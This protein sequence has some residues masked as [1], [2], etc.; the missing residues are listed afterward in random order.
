MPESLVKLED[1]RLLISDLYIPFANIERAI[2]WPH[3]AGRFEND[4]EHSFS[5]AIASAY[6]A[7]K[8]GLDPNKAAAYATVHDL[9]EVEAGDTSVW[10][11]EGLK[12]KHEREKAGFETM[13][14]KFAMFP[15]MLAM[16]EK[17]EKLEDEEACLVFTLDKSLALIM[18]IEDNGKFWKDNGITYEAHREKANIQV[19]DKLSRYPAILALY[20]ELLDIAEANKER[21]FAPQT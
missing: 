5:L 7:E 16:V 17:Y 10:D 12:T 13:K 4:A 6:A 21:L 8:L 19:R 11:E 20:E 9:L 3:E 2:T 18:I 15:W 1:V 14:A